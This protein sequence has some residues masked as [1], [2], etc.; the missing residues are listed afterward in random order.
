[1]RIIIKPQV[2]LEHY[3]PHARERL[4]RLVAEVKASDPLVPVT[5]A[6]PTQYAGL[7]LRRGLA[8]GGGLLNVRFMVVARLAEYL[9]APAMAAQDKRPLTPLVELAAIRSIAGEM[10]GRSLLGGVAHHSS[11]HLSLR[12]T[13]QDLARLAEPDLNRL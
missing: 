1:M 5:V 3:G 8:S 2:Y 12:D 6:V 10:A 9:G 11:L 13:F 7:S 4:A